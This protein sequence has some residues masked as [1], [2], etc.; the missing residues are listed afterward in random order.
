M[1]TTWHLPTER[2]G[3]THLNEATLLVNKQG[4]TRIT[5]REGEAVGEKTLGPQELRSQPKSLLSPLQV[6][7]SA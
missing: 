6:L 3:E 1:L 2:K 7:G 5:Y 4:T